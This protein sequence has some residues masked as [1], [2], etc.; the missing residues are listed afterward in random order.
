M[1]NW[2]PLQ[3]ISQLDEVAQLS[4][5]LPCVVFKHSTR[6]PISSMAKFRLEEGWNFKADEVNTYYLDLIQFRHLSNE[7]AER[8]SVHHESPQL[9]LLRNGECTYEASHLDITVAELRECFESTF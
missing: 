2:I 8:F 4:H 6:C 3:E 9:I 5:S 1:I 7:V